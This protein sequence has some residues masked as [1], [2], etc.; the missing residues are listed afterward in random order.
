MKSVMFKSAIAMAIVAGSAMSASASLKGFV[1]ANPEAYGSRFA[2][3]GTDNGI[4][5][6]AGEGYVQGDIT[7]QNGWLTN[8]PPNGEMQVRNGVGAGNGSPNALRLSVGPQPQGTFGL[9]EAPAALSSNGLTVDTR[10]DDNGGG[11]YFV[12]GLGILGAGA[13]LAFRVEFDYRGTIFLQNPNSNSGTLIDTLVPWSANAYQTLTVSI[14]ATAISYQYGATPLGTTPISTS[15][16][17]FDLVQFGH[18]NF[19]GFGSGPFS[20]GGDPAA[21]Y[22]DNLTAIPAPGAFALL[23]LGGLV[24]ARRRRA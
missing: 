5:F 20:T 11:N 22:F 13:F 14:G 18:D 9:A 12:R 10:I 2:V 15:G 4:G 8:S 1:A 24:A 23:G 3:R 21:G 6:E 16:S 7:G 17:I 19:Q